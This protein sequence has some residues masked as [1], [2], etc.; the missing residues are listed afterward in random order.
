MCFRFFSSFFGAVRRKTWRWYDLDLWL[1]NDYKISEKFNVDSRSG[2]LITPY[3]KIKTFHWRGALNERLVRK[4]SISRGN[5]ISI[6]YK[7]LAVPLVWSVLGPVDELAVEPLCLVQLNFP[8]RS[9]TKPHASDS[10]VHKPASRQWEQVNTHS[11]NH[12]SKWKL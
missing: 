8:V 6:K 10:N 12:L 9:W 1:W 4:R 11:R 5:S 7:P 2:H 3:S